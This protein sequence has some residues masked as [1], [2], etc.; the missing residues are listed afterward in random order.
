MRKRF[1]SRVAGSADNFDAFRKFHTTKPVRGGPVSAL[2][3]L[4]KRYVMKQRVPKTS[5]V[6]KSTTIKPIIERMFSTSKARQ[7]IANEI[8][9]YLV[10]NPSAARVDIL[11]DICS[12][13]TKQGLVVD[14][15]SKSKLGKIFTQP[16]TQSAIDGVYSKLIGP[17]GFIEKK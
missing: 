9:E 4:R 7:L 1:N 6:L 14:Y 5:H 11:A 10:K 12:K 13:L 16:V 3:G 2:V 8:V 15:S 17:N